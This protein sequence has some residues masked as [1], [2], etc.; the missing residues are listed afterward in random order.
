M[1][2]SFQLKDEKL[3]RVF[4]TPENQ[5]QSKELLAKGYIKSTKRRDFLLD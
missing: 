2:L 3:K 4:Y 5:R 1:I